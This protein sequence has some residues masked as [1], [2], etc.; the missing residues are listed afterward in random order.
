VGTASGAVVVGGGW[1]G[2][3]DVAVGAAGSHVVA[4]LHLPGTTAVIYRRP[5]GT[6]TTIATGA[7]RL[8]KIAVNAADVWIAYQDEQAQL[9]RN[10]QVYLVHS[11]DGGASFGPPQRLSDGRGRQERPAIGLLADGRPVVAWQAAT[12]SAVEV[13]AWVQGD[14][15]P[16]ALSL[17]G[18]TIVPPNPA[19]TRSAR[20]PASLFPDIA[21]LPDAVVVSWQDDRNDPDPLWTGHLVPPGSTAG[22]TSDPDAWEPMVA[23]R[24]LPESVWSAPVRVAPTTDRA[25]CHPALGAAAD[26]TLVCAWDSRQLRSSGTSPVITVA[27]S[28]DRGA[29]WSA[30]AEVD[31]APGFFAQRPRLAVDPDGDVRMV[32]Y[33][34]RGDDWRWAVRSAVLRGGSWILDG[35]VLRGGSCTWP[36]L[37]GGVVVAAT[38]RAARPQR[39][40][41]QEIV[42][43]TVTGTPTPAVP[44]VPLPVVLPMVAAGIGAAV[45]RVRRRGSAPV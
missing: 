15:A 26:G 30:P 28:T 19:D 7:V 43:A 14:P 38:D 4:E 33:D 36:A 3:P 20:Y 2:F 40:R 5:D 21:V 42:L 13:L 32:W 9:P 10:P 35:E 34:A 17:A 45:A 16:A 12:G 8:P 27:T 22:P 29:T 25:Q 44:E 41:T 23:V 24:R 31:K 18:K 1:S 39:D 11:S 6:R 37:D